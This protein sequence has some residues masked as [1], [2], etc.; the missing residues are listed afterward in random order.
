M[1]SRVCSRVGRVCVHISILVWCR[2]VLCGLWTVRCTSAFPTPWWSSCALRSLA[3]RS[4]L[5]FTEPHYCIL[6]RCEAAR[7]DIPYVATS[8]LSASAR[9]LW[10]RVHM[11]APSAVSSAAPRV[12]CHKQQPRRRAGHVQQLEHVPA[13]AV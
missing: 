7:H 3:V 4:D 5:L 1:N 9:R 12:E 6:A 2:T 10:P 13:D 8:L 11:A